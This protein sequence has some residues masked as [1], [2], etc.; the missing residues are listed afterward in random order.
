MT[1]KSIDIF[2]M[3]MSE[4]LYSSYKH[5]QDKNTIQR[6]IQSDADRALL[7]GAHNKI[8]VTSLPIR[9]ELVNDV[10]MAMKYKN[11]YA[12]HPANPTY[13]LSED[14]IGNPELSKNISSIIRQSKVDRVNVIPYGTTNEFL[15]L[16]DWL[17]KK[18]PGI[19]VLAPESCSQEQLFLREYVDQKSGFRDYWVRSQAKIK[20]PEGFVCKNTDQAKKA[21]R[22]F[23]SV[24]KG[25]LFK[26]DTG[27]S[28]WGIIKFEYENNFVEVL[29]KIDQ[30]LIKNPSLKVITI[31]V[32]ELIDIDINQLGG[33]PSLEYS[34]S[35]DKNGKGSFKFE[36]LCEQVVTSQGNFEGIVL[37]GNLKNS[38]W[39]KLLKK[40]GDKFA[41]YMSK[42]GYRG[43]FDIDFVI[44]KQGDVYAIESN[45]RRTGGTHVWEASKYLLGENIGDFH[46]Y[47]NDVLLTKESIKDYSRLK[48]LLS[49]LYLGNFG[50]R[51][52]LL[53]SGSNMLQYGKFGYI[54]FAKSKLRLNKINREIVKRVGKN[55]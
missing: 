5:S 11:V 28:G 17:K 54:V 21:A 1:M 53:V 34:L 15:Q 4:L 3:N 32:E 2:V 45:T 8:I 13:G 51:E 35:Q 47:S 24:K 31:V 44:S 7:Y 52:G 39:F 26:H 25:F 14:I 6:I 48:N 36:Y 16:V 27:V 37:Y 9:G 46:I 29:K 40:S 12:V 33:S 43:V 30:N 22:Y 49:D 50:V 23:Y 42:K 41:D 55:S 18:L 19:K 38:K 20:C 10:I